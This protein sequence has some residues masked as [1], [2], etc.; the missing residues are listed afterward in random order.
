MFLCDEKEFPGLVPLIF[1]FLDEAEV[2]TETRNTITQYLTFIQ[3]RA[4]G[5]ISTLAKWMR[6]YVQKHPKYAKDSYVPDETIYDM[7]K[8]MDEISKGDKQCSE[9]LGNFSSQTKRDIP[10]A[11][12]R[13]EAIIT[14]AQKKDVAS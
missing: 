13:G 6:N 5:K 4:S 10:T 14:A 3:N 2:D 8:T 12:C 1:Q 11:V 9:L 7:I